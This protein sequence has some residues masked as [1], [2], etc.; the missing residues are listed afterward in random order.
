MSYLR[1]TLAEHPE[2]KPQILALKD[3]ALTASWRRNVSVS[4]PFVE[5]VMDC[6]PQYQCI[7]CNTERQ[8]VAF[9]LSTP[10]TWN[11]TIQDLPEGWTL[12]V[13]R[14][15]SE[16][17][18]RQPSN[19]LSALSIGVSAPLRRQ[20]LG[21]QLI[22]ALRQVASA[23]GLSKLV[24]PVHPSLK[25]RYPLIPIEEYAFWTREDGLPFDPWMRNHAR[26]GARILKAAPC[27]TVITGTVQEW[28]AWTSMR[29]PQSGSYI[30]PEGLAPL[31]I[32]YECNEGRYE[33]PDVWMEHRVSEGGL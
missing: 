20:G 31:T 22:Q 21:N 13:K 19:T 6:F 27:S 26:L 8:V 16:Y 25:Y 12:V 9:G 23:R 32:S 10:F 33:N 29:L 1:T 18:Q 7:V 4:R 30:L 2:L 15:I 28:E 24:A 5:C 17:R 3:E 14:S 11:G